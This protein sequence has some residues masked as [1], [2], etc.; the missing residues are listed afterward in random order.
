MNRFAVGLSWRIA[1]IVILTGAVV[2]LYASQSNKLWL[3]VALIVTGVLSL[4]LYQY[5]TG[6]NRKL[7]RFLES[8]RYSDFTVAFRAD[9]NF[10]PSF[11]GLND[12]FNE[13]LDAFRQ[14]RA[15][16][17]ANLHYVNTI[18]QHVSVGL[19]TFDASGQVELVNQTALRLLGI[20]RLRTLTDLNA[21]HPD[22]AGLLQS[23]TNASAPVAYQTGTDGELSV[24]CTAVRL[25]GRLVTVASLQN[26][27]T[28]LQQRELDAWQ[29]LTKVL[30]HEIMNSITPIVSLAGTMRD[31]V[32]MDLVPALGPDAST[33]APSFSVAASLTDLRDA[34][35]TIE[36]R[37]AGVMQFVDA[38]RHFTTIPQPIFADVP[39]ENLLRNVVQLFQ[40]EVQKNR[41]TITTTSPNLAIRADTAQIE[42]VLL[43]LV[44][45]AVESLEKTASPSIQIE[46]EAD[47]PYVIIRVSDNGPG[48][49]PEALEQIFIPFYTTKKTGSGIGLSLSR[50]IM[51]LHGGQLTAESKPGQGST[52]KLVF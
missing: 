9:N 43:N 40:P 29:N 37:G 21:T 11:R 2:A 15:E 16:K 39:V 41:V 36:Q 8:V 3:V 19:L 48:I 18:V 24:R 32:E 28:E 49:E 51:Q 47:G 33:M 44:K 20:Y 14:A 46:A 38:Y 45:N 6:L 23:A 5:V 35:T 27:R 25:R 52:F 10:G 30:R 1:T 13:V 22:L 42:M 7:T 12:Q 17:E 34:L 4:N 50:Q 26:I 31:I